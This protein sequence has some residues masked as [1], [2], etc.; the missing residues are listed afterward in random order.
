VGATH[1]WSREVDPEH[2]R[3][4][5]AA[6]E[7]YAPGGVPHLLLEVLAYPIDEVL[8]GAATTVVVTVHGDGSL[9]VGDDG[10]GTEM[11]YDASGR[12]ARKPVMGT[13]DLR[14]FGRQDAPVLADGHPRSG[15]SVVAALSAW[16]THTTRR[17]GR[18]WVQRYERGLP[19]GPLIE[20]A[21]EGPSGTTVRFRPDPAVFASQTV[22]AGSLEA[23]CAEAAP[24]VD[25]LVVV[26][27]QA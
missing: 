18:S 17:D 19:V 27:Q 11:R 12:P 14:F 16:L 7:R 1:D 9:S 5:R 26:E 21:G 23:W 24:S 22:P 8:H 3:E 25:V 20:T 2:L 13:R 4:V 15:I 6:P 10:R